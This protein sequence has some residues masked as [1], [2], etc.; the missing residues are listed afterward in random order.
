LVV[1]VA[2][3]PLAACSE[4]ES[5]PK[6]PHP[7]RVY[8]K[9]FVMDMPQGFYLR[10]FTSSAPDLHWD[11][12]HLLFY[13]T[14]P[15]FGA[16]P[17]EQSLAIMLEPD[18]RVNRRMDVVIDS[19]LDA[20]PQDRRRFLDEMV[21]SYLAE[22]NYVHPLTNTLPGL[23]RLDIVPG[24]EGLG[25]TEE[26][27]AALYSLARISA[28]SEY[29]AQADVFFKRGADGHVERAIT[30]TA[31]VFGPPSDEWI[32]WQLPV[33]SHHFYIHDLALTV[34]VRYIRRFVSDWREIEARITA[35]VKDNVIQ[36]MEPCSVGED[37]CHC[38]I[39]FRKEYA[40][41]RHES[42]KSYSYDPDD[43]YF[44]PIQQCAPDQQP[45]QS[46]TQ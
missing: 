27:L 12:G 30:C 19:N 44:D 38:A 7:R 2:V 39:Y 10:P 14:W 45:D 1:L 36:R 17:A 42:S 26:F 16:I 46:M 32:K 9:N 3:V 25:R 28:L 24:L 20:R 4:E 21:P 43:P 41:F 22:Q 13:T 5:T 34:K 29:P 6:N 31:R 40:R 37:P 8:F 15:E 33:C 35:L 11:V 23:V 18:W